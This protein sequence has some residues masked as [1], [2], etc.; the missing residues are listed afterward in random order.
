VSIFFLLL[1]RTE[2]FT[3]WSSFFLGFIWSVS[4]SKGILRC[5]VLF[6][7]ISTYQ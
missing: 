4:Y 1:S 6:W 2:A 3:F 5:F 7:L